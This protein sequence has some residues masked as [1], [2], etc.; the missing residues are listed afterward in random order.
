M[1]FWAC[2]ARCEVGGLGG[3]AEGL[4]VKSG[5]GRSLGMAAGHAGSFVAAEGDGV[6]VWELESPLTTTSTSQYLPRHRSACLVRDPRAG[7]AGAVVT[8]TWRVV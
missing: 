4:R 7:P 6:G 1:T 2:R 8:L 5:E 3:A